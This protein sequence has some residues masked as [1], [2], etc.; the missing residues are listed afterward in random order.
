LPHPPQFC[1]SDDAF[2]HC[3]PQAV[4]PAPQAGPP[5]GLLP[6]TFPSQPSIGIAS[7]PI[8]SAARTEKIEGFIATTF[9]RT[10]PLVSRGGGKLQKITGKNRCHTAFSVSRFLIC[11]I[12]P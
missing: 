12:R 11:L 1:G 5:V 8:A 10:A 4:W 2:T 9:R 3:E 6:L 7:D